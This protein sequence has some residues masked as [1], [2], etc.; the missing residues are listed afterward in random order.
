[1][2]CWMTSSDVVVDEIDIGGSWRHA[3]P[4]LKADDDDEVV[5]G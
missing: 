5:F 4:G 3:S 2:S 1:M